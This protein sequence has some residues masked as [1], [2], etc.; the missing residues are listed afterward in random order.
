MH[1]R[2]NS[3]KK[4]EECKLIQLLFQGLIDTPSKVFCYKL[5]FFFVGFKTEKFELLTSKLINDTYF[6]LVEQC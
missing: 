3:W 6:I 5:F 1:E 4:F 2:L